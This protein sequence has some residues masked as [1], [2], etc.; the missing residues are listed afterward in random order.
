M[1]HTPKPWRIEIDDDAYLIKS[2]KNHLIAVIEG[3]VGEYEPD[4]YD[5]HLMKA[6]PDLYEVAKQVKHV[7]QLADDPTCPDAFL[8]AEVQVL[9]NMAKAAIALVDPPDD[10]TNATLENE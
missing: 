8:I 1:L 4:E 10:M 3:E 5:A 2:G 6:S 9:R 7:G